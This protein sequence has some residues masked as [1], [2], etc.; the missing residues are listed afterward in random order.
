MTQHYIQEAQRL[1]KAIDIA[2]DSFLKYTPKDFEQKHTD[3]MVK[4]YQSL[5]EG[6]FNGDARWQN[7]T[8]LKYLVNDVFIYFQESSG[9]GVDYFWRQIADQKL[10]YKRENKVAKILKRNRI[11]DDIEY[12][13]ITDVMV[14]YE[15]E[16]IITAEEAK[17]LNELLV[18]F[19]SK[20]AKD[21]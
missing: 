5:K 12:E 6:L 16:N 21:R 3:H 17:I 18:K 4:V 19:E 15:Q 7:L 9:A 10:G 14:P 8:S 11:K 2:I 20:A 13:F 1:G